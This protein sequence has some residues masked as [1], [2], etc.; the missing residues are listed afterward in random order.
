MKMKQKAEDIEPVQYWARF[1]DEAEEFQYGPYSTVYAACKDMGDRSTPGES[2]EVG[3]LRPFV[4]RID[5]ERVFEWMVD[6]NGE[7]GVDSSWPSVQPG[8][9]GILEARLDAVLM[10][11]LE[12]FNCVPTCGDIVN[13]QTF[14]LVE[15]QP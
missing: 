7:Y 15:A 11:W 1:T 3:R 2:F 4:P 13:I 5:M 12:E 9:I 8:D 6:A 10:Q 14:E